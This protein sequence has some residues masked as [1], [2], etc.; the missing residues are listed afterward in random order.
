MLYHNL[1]DSPTKISQLTAVYYPDDPWLARKFYL[2]FFMPNVR[3]IK[4]YDF[5]IF[6]SV[7]IIITWKKIFSLWTLSRCYPV[8]TFVFRTK[9][10]NNGHK[11][12]IRRRLSAHETSPLSKKK[13]LTIF[14]EKL[15]TFS[16]NL[17]NQ[18]IGEK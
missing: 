6:L 12:Y 5:L 8:I 2:T 17:I 13:V 14:N 15:N 11:I 10:P 4:I 1:I 7:E 18:L 3:M 9:M 16:L